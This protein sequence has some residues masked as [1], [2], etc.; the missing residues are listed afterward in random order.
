[1]SSKVRW[2]VCVSRMEERQIHTKVFESPEEK[3]K[4]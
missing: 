1:M 3:R 4:I 2:P